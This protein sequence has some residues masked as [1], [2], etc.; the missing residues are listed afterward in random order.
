MATAIGSREDDSVRPENDAAKQRASNRPELKEAWNSDRPQTRQLFDYA[1]MLEDSRRNAGV[2]AAGVVIGDRRSSNLLP[3]KP[4]HGGHDSSR[5]TRWT[6]R[7]SRPAEDGFS[8]AEDADRHRTRCDDWASASADDSAID[9]FRSTTKP[10][11]DLLNR[12]ETLGVFQLESGGMRDLSEQF[13]F[14]S[15]E[16]I[17]ALIALYRPGPM[18]LIPE[19][20]KRGSGVKIEVKYEHPLLERSA[21][22]P[23][24][25]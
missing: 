25:S 17:T 16:H 12:G 1:L 13:Q 24:A 18:E 8:R 15:V 7:R 11:Y 6:R 19:F 23:T 10:P 14:S 5:N 22:R 4:R 2:H 9:T 3:L 20:I 21:P